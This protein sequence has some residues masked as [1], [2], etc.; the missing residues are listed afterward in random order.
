MIVATLFG[1]LACVSGAPQYKYHGQFL[2]ELGSFERMLDDEIFSMQ[3]FWTQLRNDMLNLENSLKDITRQISI[4]SPTEKIEGNA[5]QIKLSLPDYEEKDVSVEMGRGL[6][7]IEAYKMMDTGSMKHLIYS[8]MLPLNVE[9]TGTWEFENNV[10]TVTIPLKGVDAVSSNNDK[11]DKSTE[12]EHSREEL[13]EDDANDNMN[14]DVG[15]ETTMQPELLTNEIPQSKVE[16][17][18]YSERDSD[19]D[20]VPIRYK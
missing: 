15:I 9:D 5:Y 3:N 13:E 8:K 18:T 11:E 16:A 10:L 6:L 2:N 7:K 17:T 20:F 19:I 14:A 4:N 1:L 12:R